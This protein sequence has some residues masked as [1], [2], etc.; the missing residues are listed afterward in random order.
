MMWFKSLHSVAVEEI[1]EDVNN[2]LY[3]KDGYQR[4]LLLV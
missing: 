2:V 1:W 3:M 4:T